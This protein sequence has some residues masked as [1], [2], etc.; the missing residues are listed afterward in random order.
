MKTR[1]LLRIAVFAIM[2]AFAAGAMLITRQSLTIPAFAKGV[3][4]SEPSEDSSADKRD[5]TTTTKDDDTKTEEPKEDTTSSPPPTDNRN[6]NNPSPKTDNS[7]FT[8]NDEHRDDTPSTTPQQRG[9]GTADVSG[10]IVKRDEHRDP[11]YEFRKH[12]I[13][14]TFY[15]YDY[16]L[17]SNYPY[18]DQGT[19]I[20]IDRDTWDD[21]RLRWNR[22]YE[23]AHPIPGSLEEA[24]VDIEAT[25]WEEEPEFLMLHVD[26]TSNVD[27]YNN[28]KFSHSL[29]PRQIY[30]LTVEALTRI[31]T[32]EF[33]FTSVDKRGFSA[34]ANARHEFIGPDRHKRTMYLT[35]YLEKNRQRWIIERIDMRDDLGSPKCFIATAAFG[36]PMEEEV[37]VLRQFRNR[38][39]LTNRPGR[40]FVAAYYKVSPPIARRIAGCETARAIVRAELRPIVQLCRLVVPI[41][42]K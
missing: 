29:T 8:Q 13:D 27:I 16:K 4:K 37:M 33:R 35:Y 7:I 38:Y 9:E 28:G 6:D 21:S 1:I 31:D 41:G 25:W 5:D 40:M 32:T 12:Y 18:Y 22:S 17:H 2:A 3:I 11:D 36:T 20:I 15:P 24:L 39:L 23:Y 34:R 26:H 19:A 14:P 42:V 30:K 10:Q